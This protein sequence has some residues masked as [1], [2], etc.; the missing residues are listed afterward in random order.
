M[1]A[2]L[3]LRSEKAKSS[4][5]VFVQ[6][7]SYLSCSLDKRHD[8]DKYKSQDKKTREEQTKEWEA[9]RKAAI[10]QKERWVE[11]FINDGCEFKGELVASEPYGEYIRNKA[12]AAYNKGSHGL[13]LMTD[14]FGQ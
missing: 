12:E 13:E 6:H 7:V 8:T 10:E 11:C 9:A 2:A 5:R 4:S 3:K 14:I 1:Q